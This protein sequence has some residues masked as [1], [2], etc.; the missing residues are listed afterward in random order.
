[1]SILSGHVPGTGI[2]LERAVAGEHQHR[3]GCDL[4]FSAPKSVSLEA[5][6]HGDWKVMRAHDMAVS[7]GLQ[8]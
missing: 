6:L 2:R 7:T 4:T 1:M 3:L 8:N 5:L